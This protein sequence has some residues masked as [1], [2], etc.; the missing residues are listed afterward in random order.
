M[1]YI[2]QSKC[3]ELCQPLKSKAPLKRPLY[4]QSKQTN[5]RRQKVELGGM[6][7]SYVKQIMIRS[8]IYNVTEII[9]PYL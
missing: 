2:Q 1:I 7:T 9:N 8:H 5:G 4:Y 6:I 3:T